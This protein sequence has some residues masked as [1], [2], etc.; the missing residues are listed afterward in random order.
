MPKAM[1]KL[2]KGAPKDC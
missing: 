1:Q 2:Q